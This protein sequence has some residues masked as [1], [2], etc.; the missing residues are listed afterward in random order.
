MT[1]TMNPQKQ[2]H[3]LYSEL[4][5]E[6]YSELM[7]KMSMYYPQINYCGRCYPT[8]MPCS[9]LESVSTL[10]NMSAL[11]PIQEK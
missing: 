7:L 2:I 6:F 11:L 9:L 4:I 1:I 3:E 10:Q 8:T 5:H